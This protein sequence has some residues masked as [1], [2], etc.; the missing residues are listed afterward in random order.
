MNPKGMVKMDFDRVIKGIRADLA[1]HAQR[2]DVVEAQLKNA[3]EFTDKFLSECSK[4]G[5]TKIAISKKTD[6]IPSSKEYPF[7]VTGN[8]FAFQPKKRAQGSW[9][10]I[11]GVCEKFGIGGGCGN[12]DQHQI[13]DS[14]LIDGVY[15]LKSGKWMRVD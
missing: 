10:P 11:W 2:L 13:D 9:P 1:D 3:R 4:A 8:V 5:I 6:T 14:S 15:H 12:S 7:G